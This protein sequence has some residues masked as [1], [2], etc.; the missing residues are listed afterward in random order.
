MSLLRIRQAV[1][2]DGYRL[3]LTLTDGSTVERD[4]S[5]LLTGPVFEPIRRDPRLFRQVRVEHGTVTWPGDVDLC[6]DVLI[7]LGPPP[8]NDATSKP[9]GAPT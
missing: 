2:L 3:R 5:N 7:W 4:V 1:P 9:Y 8:Q 6:P